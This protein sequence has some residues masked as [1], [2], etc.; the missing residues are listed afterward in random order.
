M[1][2]TPIANSTRRSVRSRRAWKAA[3]QMIMIMN[4]AIRLNGRNVS[5]EIGAASR[6]QIAAPMTLASASVHAIV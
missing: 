6:K 5:R 3:K 2:S 1:P 4:G